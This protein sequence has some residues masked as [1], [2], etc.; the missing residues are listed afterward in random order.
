MTEIIL[1]ILLILALAAVVF[2]LV[3]K[4]KSGKQSTPSAADE[5]ITNLKAQLEFMAQQSAIIQT[6]M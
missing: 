6:Q 5:G 3:R 1:L 4:D 2:L